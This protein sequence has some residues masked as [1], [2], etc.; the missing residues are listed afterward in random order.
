MQKT[1]RNTSLLDTSITSILGGAAITAIF[2][3]YALYGYGLMGI[4]GISMAYYAKSWN[5]FSRLFKNLKLCIDDA[6]PI[7]KKKKKTDISTIY[8]FTLPCGMSVEDFDKKKVAIEQHLGREIEIKYTYKEIQIEVFEQRGTPIFDYEPVNIFGNVPILVGYDRKGELVSADLSNGEPHMLIA[9]ET[10]SGKSTALRSIITNLILKSNVTLHLVDLKRGAEFSVFAKSSKVKSFSRTRGEANK[11]LTEIKFEIERRY[12]LFFEND[13]ADI[14]EYNRRHKKLDY[15]VLVIDEFADLH[16]E[17]E[18]IENLESI[19]ALAR[20]CGI[21]LVIATQRPD[22]KI[23]N[24]RI[25]ANVANVLGLKTMNSTNSQIIIDKP[26][27]EH[28]RGKGHGIF[29]RGKESE[30][31]CPFLSIENCRELIKHTYVKKENKTSEPSEIENF[32]FLEG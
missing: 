9:G 19:A 1:D 4:G 17:K 18:S 15:Q 28:L 25:K 30:I 8:C 22:H 21:H 5:K 23:L 11:I 2:P 14:K 31:Q 6:Y 10:G 26:C 3:P 24:G 29:K 12:D 13:V 32:D 20:A 27:L 7:Y 16:S